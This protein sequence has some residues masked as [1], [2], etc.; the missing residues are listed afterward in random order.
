ML[1]FST[2]KFNLL[3]LPNKSGNVIKLNQLVMEIKSSRH[4]SVAADVIELSLPWQPNLRADA[5]DDIDLHTFSD[6][7]NECVVYGRVRCDRSDYNDRSAPRVHTP[8]TIDKH[9]VSPAFL[10]FRKLFQ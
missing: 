2:C 9:S 10:R 8:A 1:L 6:M 4:C 5:G 7:C 3:G